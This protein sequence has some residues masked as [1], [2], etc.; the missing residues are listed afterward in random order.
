[1]QLLHLHLEKINLVISRRTVH[2]MSRW[3]HIH[4]ILIHKYDH[5]SSQQLQ[6]DHSHSTKDTAEMSTDENVYHFVGS[7]ISNGGEH[8]DCSIVTNV[9]GDD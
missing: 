4:N 1:M 3:I 8:V 5:S 6:H 7:D 2:P 9:R